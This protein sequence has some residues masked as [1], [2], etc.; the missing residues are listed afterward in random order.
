MNRFCLW[1]HKE[2]IVTFSWS[3]IV[4]KPKPKK[5]CDACVKKTQR[6]T[7]D[8]CQRCG[9]SSKG[10]C[11]DC[12]WW[13]RFFSNNDPLQA[14]KSLYQYNEFMQDVITK[15]KYRGDYILINAFADDFAKHFSSLKE[16]DAVAIPIPLSSERLRERGFNQAKQLAQFL[17]IQTKS[18]LTRTHSEKQAKKTRYERIREANPFSVMQKINKTVILVDDIYTTGATIRHAATVLKDAG[19]PQIY[20]YTLIRG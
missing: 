8:L 2:I 16:K 19:C 7:G 14:N 10:I 9:R 4:T 18:I 17:P 15:W 20:S 6:L 13:E 3:T 12:I 11:S 1:C 5:L